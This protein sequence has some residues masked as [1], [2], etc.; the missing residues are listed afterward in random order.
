VD[1]EGAHGVLV[2]GGGE[3]YGG[4][5]VDEFENVEAGELGHLHVEKD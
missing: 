1:F 5:G 4:V 2:V 3:D